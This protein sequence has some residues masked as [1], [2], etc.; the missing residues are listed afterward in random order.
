MGLADAHDRNI[1]SAGGGGAGVFCAAAGAVTSLPMIM[2]ELFY[3]DQL[4]YCCVVTLL[5]DMRR[6]KNERCQHGGF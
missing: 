3:S 1:G 5:I 4:S 2:L 6:N